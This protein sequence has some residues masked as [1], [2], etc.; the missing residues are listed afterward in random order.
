MYERRR[1]ARR[2]LAVAGFPS[3]ALCKS[4]I[5]LD[6]SVTR[7]ESDRG[8]TSPIEVITATRDTG[9]WNERIEC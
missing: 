5:S 3:A 9:I 7:R 6:S 1:Q 8:I 4:S 2:T